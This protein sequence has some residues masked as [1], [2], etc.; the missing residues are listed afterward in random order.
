MKKITMV[1]GTEQVN[2]IHNG[3]S[4]TA[5]EELINKKDYYF[6]TEEEISAFIKGVEET[7]GWNEFY[8]LKNEKHS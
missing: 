2:K 4:L 7:I 3:F 5:E 1:F 6:N 8:F